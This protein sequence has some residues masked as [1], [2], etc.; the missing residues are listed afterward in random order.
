MKKLLFLC[1]LMLCINVN[2]Q[3]AVLLRLNYE[4][5]VTYDI[6]MKSL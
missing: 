3:E 5:G 2:A 4:K 6:S 1:F